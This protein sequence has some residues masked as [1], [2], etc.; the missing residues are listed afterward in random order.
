MAI[1]LKEVEYIARL[2]RI[3]LDPQQLQYFTGQLDKILE[4]IN[5]LK[6]LNI[7]GVTPT[8]GV[9]SLK[10]VWREDK[11]KPS[12]EIKDVLNNAIQKEGNYFKVPK[13]IE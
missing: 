12:L 11:V 1:T 3:E 10:N 13:I 8:T 5:K 6:E 4:Y 9:L 7:S 2:A